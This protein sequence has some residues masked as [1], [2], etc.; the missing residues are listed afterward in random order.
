MIIETDPQCLDKYIRKGFEIA[1]RTWE[2][3]K[4]QSLF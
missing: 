2:K 4:I 3:G 1:Q